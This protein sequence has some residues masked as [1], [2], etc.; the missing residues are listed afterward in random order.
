MDT[1]VWVLVVAAIVAAVAAV[2]WYAWDRRRRKRLR[3]GFGPEYERTVSEYGDRRKAERD[4]ERRQERIEKLDLRPLSE[5]ERRHFTESWGST[6]ARFVDEPTE[7][8]READHLITEAM[9]ARGYPMSD[10]EQRA[11]D[12]S[13][14]HPQ[15]VEHYRSS[16]E[17]AVM[18]E[19]GEAT[20][21]Q[22]R[23]AMQHYRAVFSE[24][25]DPES[26]SEAEHREESRY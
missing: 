18:A 23:Q 26:R 24:V 10:W 19:R 5:Q 6:Q 25:V 3:E 17:V 14:E 12:L 2:A 8:I 20:T 22:L 9:R 13:V 16:H 15:V 21:E 7:A 4:L 1:W 11:D